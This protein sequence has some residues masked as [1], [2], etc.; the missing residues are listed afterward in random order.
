MYKKR[1][2]GWLKHLDFILVDII[3]LQL[4]FV[5]AYNIRFGI[6]NPY[7]DEEYL[8]LAYIYLLIDFV[9]AI[10]FD[11]FKNV[12]KRGKYQEF[13]AVLK[14]V[15][16]VEGLT[17]FYLFSIKRS[18]IYS[19]I[20]FYIMI[21]LYILLSYI[22][23][24]LWKRRLKNRYFSGADKSMI[25][26]A[27]ENQLSECIENIC[28]EGYPMYGFLG[29]VAMDADCKGQKIGDVPVV[30]NYNEVVDY[31]CR[32]WVDE[33][34]L[35]LDFPREDET[36]LIEALTHMGIAVHIAIARADYLVAKRRR[37]ERLGHYTVVTASV[38]FATPMQLALKRAMDIAGGLIG[39]L[40][41]LLLL[42]FVGPA[43]YMNSPGPIFFVQE[44]VGRNGKHFKMY[45]FRTMYLDAEARKAELMAQNRVGDGMMFKLD[46]DPRI[47]GNKLLPDGTVKEGIG[48]FLRKTSLD[49]FPQFFNV[50]KGD[51]SLV[52]TRPPTVDEWEK[53]EPHHRARLS[54]RPG[55]TGLW[56]VSGRS[57]ITDF[58][59]VV[60]L[61][62][63][64]IDE[65]SIGK[66][67]RILVR[68]IGVVLR[69]DGAL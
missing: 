26:I 9:V 27:P 52:G 45:K 32:Q 54:F 30:A 24:L 59:E 61:D 21:P 16:L 57:K 53:Y 37:I 48:S 44:R 6:G 10:L 19:R 18:A 2:E 13:I 25:I 28:A 1:N 49:E 31:V 14:H 23:R 5:L 67:L 41:T 60:K 55:L 46:Y 66:D 20:S 43:V 40:F 50:L 65:W 51:M 36:E 11:S 29:A 64:Y 47:I 69:D 4:A 35:S 63:Q 17:V 33:V 3:F 56:Q 42:I 7:Q 39:C 8:S 34:F 62:M 68:T 12:L 15:L 38:H 58:E 22:G